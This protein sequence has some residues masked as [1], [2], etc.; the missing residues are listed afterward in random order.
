MLLQ[1]HGARLP[2][3]KPGL[4]T[5]LPPPPCDPDGDGEGDADAE[6]EALGEVDGDDDG[7]GEGDEEAELLG[8]GDPLGVVQLEAEPLMSLTASL[9]SVAAGSRSYS[10]NIMKPP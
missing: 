9:N 3:S 8:L 2:V 4:T 5:L 1:V 7:D 6:A 10:E